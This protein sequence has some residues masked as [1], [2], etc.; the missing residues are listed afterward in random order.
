MAMDAGTRSA[1]R[2]S[3]VAPRLALFAFVL[4]SQL[5]HLAEHILQRLSG[6]A[7]LNAAADSEEIHLLFNG[8]IA[9]GSIFLLWSFRTNPWV[10]PLAVIAFLHEAEH[11]Y[12]YGQYLRSGL[13]GGP[14]LFGLGGAFGVIPLERLDLHNVY[15]GI[16]LVLM[17]LGAVF[18]L[19][20]LLEMEEIP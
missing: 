20:N 14:G 18:E 6:T 17:T 13:T 10:Y 9:V 7:V 1:V 12:I 2:V 19:D 4:A 5:G 15:N 3:A 16:E 11:V 8:M